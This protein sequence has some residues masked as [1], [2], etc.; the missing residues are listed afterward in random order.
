MCG[1]LAASLALC[2]AGCGAR[3]EA[4]DA[5]PPAKPDLEAADTDRKAPAGAV[6]IGPASPRIASAASAAAAAAAA[7]VVTPITVEVKGMTKALGIT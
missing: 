2:A 1:L 3:T 5:G 7:A 6:P 4:P